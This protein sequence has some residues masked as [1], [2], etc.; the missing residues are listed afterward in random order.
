[1][2]K[3][4]FTAAQDAVLPEEELAL[5]NRHTLRDLTR[6][7]VFCFS[8]TLCDNLVDRDMERFDIPAL[9]RLAALFD[10]KTGIAD[11]SMKSEDQM[12][13]IY[14]TWVEEN[15]AEQTMNGEPYTCLKAKA[16]MPV[17]EE[18]K[19]MIAQIKS[20]IKKETSVSCAVGTVRCSI[21]GS[22]M[23]PGGCRHQKGKLYDGKVC[24]AVLADPTD[25]YEWS[26]VAVPAQRSAGVTKSFTAGSAK[27]A[28]EP[29]CEE[30]VTLTRS[31][32][33]SLTAAAERLRRGLVED[34]TR[35]GVLALPALSKTA[36]TEICRGLT[37]EQL[38][39]L[40]KSFRSTAA[41]RFPLRPQLC[42]DNSPEPENNHE[43]KI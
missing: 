30:T 1:M 15:P 29:D 13:R 34:V 24:H 25:A 11:H 26:F 4:N 8:L 38:E 19:E 43:F 33:E 10:G 40:S 5:I 18:T 7:E 16:Y 17:T 42:G 14:K 31:A 12:A 32:L 23:R 35:L 36:L 20:G 37:E 41:A 3:S 21:C 22:S 6:D 27:T 9:H 39:A 2:K 28:H